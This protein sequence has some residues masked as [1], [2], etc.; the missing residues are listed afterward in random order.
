[1]AVLK[2]SGFR[3]LRAIGRCLSREALDQLVSGP[4]GGGVAGDVDMDQFSTV[5]SKDQKSEEQTEG[6]GRDNE[7]IDG[8]N[9]ANMRLEEG[10]P[11]RGGATRGAAACT[12]QW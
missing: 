2:C 5:V 6:E 1:M 4:G 10:A 12:W 8:D 9:V 3:N 11:R 7:E